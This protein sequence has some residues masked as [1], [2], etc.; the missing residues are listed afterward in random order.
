MYVFDH[1]NT[2]SEAE[3]DYEERCWLIDTLT[4]RKKKKKR[5]KECANKWMWK[6]D[7]GGNTHEITER[8]HIFCEDRGIYFRADLQQSYK[9]LDG[10]FLANSDQ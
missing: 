1:V 2:G 9:K 4:Y 5:K 3:I 8:L 10:L 7:L 6:G